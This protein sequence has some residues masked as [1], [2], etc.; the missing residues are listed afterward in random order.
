MKM[1]LWHTFQCGAT[2]YITYAYLR[3][4]IMESYRF[5]A[6]AARLKATHILTVHEPSY[7]FP[8]NTSSRA[9]P[10]NSRRP[11]VLIS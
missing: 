8:S 7:P 10:T 2:G 6:M 3:I 11:H 5:E 9:P 1:V 4:R